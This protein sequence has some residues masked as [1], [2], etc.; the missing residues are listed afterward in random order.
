MKN[1]RYFLFSLIVLFLASCQNS[2]DIMTD[3]DLIA[4]IQ[5]S[6]NKALIDASTLPAD[7]TSVLNTEYS[8]SHTEQAQLASELGYQVRVRRVRGTRM[9][10][11]G[12]VYFDLNGRELRPQ[13][14]SRDH[15]S[16]DRQEC[17][18][19]VF[20][21]TFALP[22]GTEITGDASELRH[23]ISRWYEAN[24]EAEARPELQYPVNIEF[25]DG[26]VITV[27]EEEQMRRVYGACE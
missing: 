17:F 16:R 4:A 14:G 23:G 13:R 22:D 6:G 1:T 18:N 10:E 9:G 26:S 15:D 2:E 21:V 3:S 8:E 20:P 12:D 27:Q 11:R 19:L 7:A 5:N 25:E 24:P